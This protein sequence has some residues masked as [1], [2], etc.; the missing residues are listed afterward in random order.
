[1]RKSRRRRSRLFR[2]RQQGLHGDRSKSVRFTEQLQQQRSPLVVL[3]QIQHMLCWSEFSTCCAGASSAHVCT[4]EKC[5]PGLDRLPTGALC[6]DLVSVRA[7]PVRRFGGCTIARHDV[8][9]RQQPSPASHLT[10]AYFTFMAR[11]QP[12]YRPCRSSFC[13][14]GTYSALLQTLSIFFFRALTSQI[15][16][17][18]HYH[19][20]I[21]KSRCCA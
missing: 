20:W 13:L 7:A 3:E 4:S 17:M 2:R 18:S 12:C 16:W 10:S 15:L 5:L 11:T 6:P 1:M 9:S 21:P 8:F 19:P 14:C